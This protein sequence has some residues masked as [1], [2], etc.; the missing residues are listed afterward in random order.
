MACFEREDFASG[1]S[2]RSTKLLWGGSRYLVQALVALFHYDLRLIRKPV[3]TVEAFLADFRMV[4]NCHRER[5][6]MM[7]KQ[8]HLTSWL[9]IAV[10]FTSWILWPAPFGHPIAAIGPIGIF[11]LFF[12]FYD[13]LSW[14]NC[15]PSHI[16]SK[17]RVMRKFPQ[18]GL[19]SLKYCSVFYEG[20]HDDARTN[21]AIAETAAIE[22]ALMFNYME[23]TAITRNEEG[24]VMG[25]VI[26]DKLDGQVYRVNGKTILCCGGPFSDE[27]QKM[28]LAGR[29]CHDQMNIS[30]ASPDHTGDPESVPNHQHMIDGAT[31]VH[32]VLPAYYAPKNI[33]LV[34]MST[35]DGRFLFFLPWEGS[36]LVG[37]TDRQIDTIDMRPSPTE[38]EIKWLLKEASKYL[39]HNLLIRRQDVL[40][41]WCGVRPLVNEKF[42]SRCLTQ[43]QS[44]GQDTKKVSRDHV[45]HVDA[46]DNRIVYVL[47]GKW[48]TYRE[49]AQDA[50]DKIVSL[51][52]I[53]DS[54]VTRKSQTLE[55]HLIGYEGYST[56]LAI[57]LT[58]EYHIPPE[59]AAGLVHRYGGRSRDILE[60]AMDM[61]ESTSP[62]ITKCP[63]PTGRN[64]DHRME[65]VQKGG[66]G[67]G[68]KLCK[69]LVPQ[70]SY[71]EAEI[72]YAI[73]YE[74]AVHAEDI[75][76]R[77]TR[78]AFLN[79]AETMLCLPRIIDLMALELNWSLETQRREYDQCV[80]FLRTFGGPVPVYQDSTTQKHKKPIRIATENEL[81]EML[82]TID[83]EGNGYVSRT[84]LKA[85]GEMLSY[86]LSREEIQSCV[87]SCDPTSTSK[88]HY[89]DFIRWWN[90]DNSS[91][92]KAEFNDANK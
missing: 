75:I 42:L 24:E 30:D 83:V 80:E 47:G 44:P 10:P 92:E 77:R 60:I 62:S 78:I 89:H 27:I 76:S 21:L 74:W 15:P 23:I 39:N 84:D 56:T 19:K 45:I 26:R 50:I 3:A 59:V 67:I 34:D 68:R 57:Q 58:Q 63:V 64:A 53:E 66:A 14:F 31:G 69:R 43:A 48:T 82:C 88:I 8:S 6:F 18:M 41:A 16:M 13:F 79:K 85:I 28:K 1:T 81:F 38:N 90:Q 37:T 35:S 25:V 72:I 2:S 73:R 12:K 55:R 32:V 7:S 70:L 86:P 51:G 46:Q 65:V 40:S 4:L 71:I 36:V 5:T 49:M 29:V 54:E 17:K 33:G 91:E 9:P 20:Q 61:L 11:P 87:A 22:G 52:Y